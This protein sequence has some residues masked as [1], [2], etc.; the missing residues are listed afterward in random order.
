MAW[1]RSSH[2]LQFDLIAVEIGHF[3]RHLL[4]LTTVAGVLF[5][6][7]AYK[8]GGRYRAEVWQEFTDTGRPFNREVEYRLRRVLW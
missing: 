4:F 3:M 7:D 8:F 6:I 5:A 2:D 1:A